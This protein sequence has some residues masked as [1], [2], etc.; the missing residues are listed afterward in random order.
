MIAGNL[1]PAFYEPVEAVTDSF[2][3]RKRLFETHDIVHVLLGYSTS[4]L[5]ETG[6][7]G[8]YFGQQDR[9]HP[10]GG[11]VLMVHGVI[12]ESA[13]FMHAALTDPEDCPAANASVHHRLR[14]RLRRQTVLV[15]PP[16][17][18]VDQP[19]AAVRAQLALPEPPG[20]DR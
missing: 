3:V 13:V 20:P 19:L 8:F 16:R 12:Q 4:V 9:Y 11:G 15:F 18:D 14:P 7:T 1:S 17:G 5:D 2:F 10:P 6:I